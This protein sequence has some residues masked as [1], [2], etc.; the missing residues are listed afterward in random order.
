[1]RA[2]GEW[3]S[4]APHALRQFPLHVSVVSLYVAFRLS[5]RRRYPSAVV[6]PPGTEPPFL[7]DA[8]AKGQ[9]IG[10]GG[11]LPV[12]NAAGFLDKSLA[13]VRL[14]SEREHRPMGVP[15]GLAVLKLSR[16]WRL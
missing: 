13:A 6:R 4:D 9:V 5:L 10:V 2:D 15:Q 1:M 12:R 7:I 11:W 14:R 16:S 8:S 3:R